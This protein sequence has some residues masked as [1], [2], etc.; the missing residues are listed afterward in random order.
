MCKRL[1]RQIALVLACSTTCV[2]A[3]NSVYQSELSATYTDSAVLNEVDTKTAQVS[4]IWYWNAIKRDATMPNDL[5]AFYARSP[6]I[7]VASYWQ[8]RRDLNEVRG[9]R[10]LK[11][12]DQ[13]NFSAGL[14]WAAADSPFWFNV[15]VNR[16]QDMELRFSD[17]SIVESDIAN[18]LFLQ[19]GWY[20][21]EQQSLSLRYMNEDALRMW[22]VL[23]NGYA[24]AGRLGFISWFA[25]F[26]RLKVKAVDLT[27]TNNTV[28]N[29]DT[30]HESE[31]VWRAGFTFYP[32]AHAG[33]GVSAERREF[34][35]LDLHTFSYRLD[36]HWHF[37]TL[38]RVAVAYLYQERLLSN[39]RGVGDSQALSLTLSQAF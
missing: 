29:L 36:A 39:A 2:E 9:G 1:L 35:K 6:A 5:E 24:H 10:I 8:F 4:A 32:V 23:S 25:G 12:S 38:T 16:L 3:Q 17:G 27:I 21:S 15:S 26:D 18:D 31:D 14:R 13:H 37:T 11:E 34:S 20:Y 30:I 28:R 7:A 19:T 33:L 22:G